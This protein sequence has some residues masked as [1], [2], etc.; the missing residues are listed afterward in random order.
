MLVLIGIAGWSC[1][2]SLPPRTEPAE[3]LRTTFLIHQDQDVVVQDSEVVGTA[4]GTF[5]FFVKNVHDEVLQDSQRIEV[6][7]TIWLQDQPEYRAS[8]LSDRGALVNYQLVYGELLTIG[9]D[10]AVH[11]LTQ[12]SHRTQDGTPFWSFVKLV[13][14]QSIS[15]EPY[16]QSDPVHYIMQGTVQVFKNVQPYRIPEQH[17][18]HSYKIFANKVL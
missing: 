8:V 12:W 2:E 4:E 18:S 16:L 13:P 10:T 15:G 17:F 1:D 6:K 7:L 3:V 5:E 14:M 11:I 9:V